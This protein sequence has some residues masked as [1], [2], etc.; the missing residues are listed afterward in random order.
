VFSLCMSEQWTS[1]EGSF[2]C[3]FPAKDVL[4]ADASP[5]LQRPERRAKCSFHCLEVPRPPAAL[6]TR[7]LVLATAGEASAGA[8]ANDDDEVGRDMAG[9][10]LGPQASFQI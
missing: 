9:A 5:S 6:A 8:A 1:L 2:V 4:P 3:L 10:D 7:G